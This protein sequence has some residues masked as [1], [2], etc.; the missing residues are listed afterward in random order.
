M[1]AIEIFPGNGPY[2]DKYFGT[3][4]DAL[5][6]L[7]EFFTL[8]GWV[9]H[10]FLTYHIAQTNLHPRIFKQTDLSTHDSK[11]EI[12]FHIYH[13]S[14]DGICFLFRFEQISKDAFLRLC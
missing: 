13:Y 10:Y 1:V 6:T 2:S 3:F 12:R 4:S 9:S 11:I 8:E 14:G 7:V 5:L